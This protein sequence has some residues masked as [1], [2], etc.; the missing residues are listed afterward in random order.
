MPSTKEFRELFSRIRAWWRRQCVG[1]DV[2]GPAISRLDYLD[3]YA[4]T[5]RRQ[6][7]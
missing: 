6:R 1:N 5:G 2:Y 7:Q 3:H 4:D